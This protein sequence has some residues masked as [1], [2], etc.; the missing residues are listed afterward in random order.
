[1]VQSGILALIPLQA[2]LTAVS[3]APLPAAV[4]AGAG[5]LAARLVKA[6]PAT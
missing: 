3:G 1:A 2:A 4:V 6:V 5:P